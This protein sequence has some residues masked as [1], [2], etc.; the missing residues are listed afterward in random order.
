MTF[1]KPLPPTC[2]GR[3]FEIRQKVVG[4]YDKGKAGSVLETESLVVDVE[5]GEAYVKMV[6]STFF[7]GQGNWGGPKGE[8]RTQKGGRMGL[9]IDWT[10]S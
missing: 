4:V 9:L 3:K 2:E 5:K 10:R 6:G 1:Y 8:F 7:L